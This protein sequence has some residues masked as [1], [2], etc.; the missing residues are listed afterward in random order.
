MFLSH[1][2][3]GI[4]L[5]TSDHWGGAIRAFAESASLLR[6]RGY[7]VQ[8]INGS[9]IESDSGFIGDVLATHIDGPVAE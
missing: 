6:G 1:R 8:H 3:Q 5:A 2:E 9:E 7:T 4:Q